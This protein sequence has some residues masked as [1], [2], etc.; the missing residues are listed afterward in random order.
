MASRPP[1]GLGLGRAILLFWLTI[2]YVSFGLIAPR[3]GTVVTVLLIGALSLATA[4]SLTLEMSDP[5]AGFITV[6]SAPLQKAL[7]HLRP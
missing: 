4:V 2:L 6:S 5:M 7:E 3:N 1:D